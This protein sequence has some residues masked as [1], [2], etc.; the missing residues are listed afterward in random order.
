M[1]A[2]EVSSSA[3]LGR[4]WFHWRGFSPVPLFLILLVIPPQFR[5]EVAGVTAVVVG[6]ALAE[7][8][9]IWAVGFAGSATRTR[10]DSVPQLVHAGPFRHVRNPLYI[11][12]ILMYTLT[13]L[14]FGSYWMAA[15]I[16]VYSSLQYHFIVAFEEEVLTQT[17][18]EAY[19]NYQSKVP[20]WLP[21]LKAGMEASPHTFSLGKALASEKSTFV[22]FAALFGLWALRRSFIG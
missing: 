21:T 12:N 11:A 9:R 22:A 2:Q 14:L 6:I 19:R 15:A 10:G 18:G 3:R 8:L 1:V 5:L 16:L 4:I 20:R 13:G 17:F 7:L